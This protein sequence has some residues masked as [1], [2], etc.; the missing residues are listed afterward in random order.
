MINRLEHTVFCFLF[1]NLRSISISLSVLQRW[2]RC[3]EQYHCLPTD[4]AN[5]TNSE[6]LGNPTAEGII[7]ISHHLQMLR[8]ERISFEFRHVLPHT[9]FD[10]AEGISNQNPIPLL[11]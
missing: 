1:F 3:F 6:H 7:D 2:Y 9:G 10:T 4:E 8:Q 11:V 5:M